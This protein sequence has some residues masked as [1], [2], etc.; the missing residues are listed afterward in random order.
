MSLKK[1][2]LKSKPECKVTFSISK[3]EM[4]GGSKAS[5]VGD[6]NNWKKDS[7]PLKRRKG[8]DYSV[9][10]KLHT[11]KSY[12]YKYIVDDTEWIL[13]SGDDGRIQ[14]EGLNTENSVVSLQKE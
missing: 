9:Q 10:L 3:E 12:E 5:V 8:G 4:N 14:V 7:H 6:F 13:D 11:G 1:Q 2:F